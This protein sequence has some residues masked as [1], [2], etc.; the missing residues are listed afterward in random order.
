M[1][2]RPY[3]SVVPE[4]IAPR[5]AGRHLVAAVLGL[6]LASTSASLQTPPP[7]PPEVVGQSVRLDPAAASRVTTDARAAIPARL[8]D[9]LILSVWA[10]ADLAPASL[11]AVDLAPDGT[12]YI[13]VARRSGGPLDTRQHPDWVP[14]VLSLRT[15]EALRQFF[16]RRIA[17]ADS[18][19]NQ[20]LPDHNQDGV[21]DYRDLMHVQDRVYR[22]ADTNDDGVA[23]TS[24]LVFSGFNEDMAGDILGGILRHESGDLYVTIAPDLWRLR[25]T[26]GDGVF[27]E[28]TSIS[29]GYSVH[30]SFSAHGLSAPMQGPD[31]MIYW[32]IG[33]I[34]MHVV[35]KSGREW[36]YPHTGAVLRANPDGTDFEVYASGVR[37]PHEIAFDEH[38]DLFAVD[39]DGD[40]P[41]ELERLIY[42]AQGSDTG[43]RS[44]WQYG[45]YTDP[46]N[47]RYNP[48]LD[49]GMSKVWF[50]GQP[51]HITPPL[52]PYYT[53]PSGFAY[54]P[55]TA[56]GPRWARHF[57]GTSYNYNAATAVVYGFT[58]DPKGAGFE[59][60]EN[61][62]VA[63][64]VLS[65]G[66]RVGPDGALYLT[67][68]S[69]AD[70]RIVKIDTTDPTNRAIRA[71]VQALL[72]ASFGDRSVADLRALLAHADMRVRQKAQFELVRRADDDALL[73]T[74]TD[75]GHQLA[76][77]HAI[78]GLGQLLRSH[79]IAAP[80]ITPFLT[81]ADSE[82]R[83]Q[84]AKVLGHARAASAAG[85]LRPLVQD[86]D[87]RV[88]AQA[89][90]AVGRIGDQ[91]ALPVVAAMLATDAEHDLYL[92]S[93]GVVAFTAIGDRAGLAAL[94]DHPSRGVR[95]AAVAA[96]RRL[97]DAGVARFLDD[98][99]PL[100]LAEAASAINDE[101]G[102]LPA[103]PAL[104]QL[105]D[106][107]HLSGERIVRRAISANLRVGDP[108]AVARV[109][110][111]ARRS[112]QPEALRVEAIGT[113]GAWA[114]PSNMDRVD[115]AWIAPLPARQASDA[116]QALT[117]L[118]GTLDAPDSTPALKV[119]WLDAAGRIGLTSMGPQILARLRAD[120][121]ATVRVAALRALV[122]L[123]VP[124]VSQG[125]DVAVVDS[126]ATVR[127]EAI[128]AMPALS[129]PDDTK[130]R[131]LLRVI[132]KGV[133]REQQSALG[134][135]GRIGGAEA[136]G[137]LGR[138]ADALTAGSLAPDVQLDL[139]DAM[140]ETGAAPLQARLE[141][142]RV[143]RDL[144]TV[145]TAFPAALANGGNP[146]R[147]RQLVLQHP[148]AQCA[149]C[150]TVGNAKS[151]VG[152]ALTG[153]GARLSRTQLLESL[154]DPSARL[155]PGFGQVTVT[156][157][158]GRKIEGLLR[159]ESATR[160]V[161][162]DAAGTPQTIAL[163]EVAT[164]T[165]LP[166]PMPPMGTLL[167][168][169]EIRDVV[170]F[171]ATQQQ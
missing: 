95:M 164:R 29:H 167:T 104:A 139:L 7:Q 163:T 88:R 25:D 155:A 81:D 90:I 91:A 66:L 119:A 24:T 161:V 77:I 108:A 18:D 113:L 34:G 72:I 20:W 101:G 48:W 32:K 50:E 128:S 130:V 71:E 107:E 51:A 86:Q 149:R 57:F 73:A 63:D 19:R 74:A 78:W 87:A 26:D 106:R 129:I 169:R 110:A 47:N 158:N 41:G 125:I 97:H 111:F 11:V 147:G 165:N 9:G 153:V 131:N 124:E 138:L 168:P 79:T 122:A 80:A 3:R 22:L 94:A 44:T 156:L 58:L 117:A 21:H 37:N 134:A 54:N 160:L 116:Q 27:D 137:G 93:A 39:N 40:Y 43:W 148:A 82:I 15:T 98:T 69:T 105:L 30:P 68:R 12:A 14:E 100:V 56:L 141:Q 159:E 89:T 118:V 140:R 112:A 146:Q 4:P 143:G 133:P 8:A 135:I 154:L 49:E 38:G 46:A 126:D 31:G 5:R 75:R 2:T 171:L 28:K 36:A 166:S 6:L 60:A 1:P 109:L 151:D 152:P 53:G 62:H 103:V 16:Q 136:V 150:H 70:T 170:E 55:G 35:D 114:A 23:D 123:G 13:T 92:R 83:A 76:R 157:K 64:G 65:Q 132:D 99:D 52:A 120:T 96:L 145:G 127:T 10:T 59:L 45:K 17:T 67:V 115:G 102:I 144:S 84:A 42:I 121:D 61:T 33:E 162:E 142:L 85:A